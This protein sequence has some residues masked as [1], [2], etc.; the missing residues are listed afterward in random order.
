[1]RAQV[2][3]AVRAILVFTV[4][5]G[6]AYPLAIT[7]I[8]QLAFDD[9]ADGSLIRNAAGEVVGS[10]LLGQT[11]TSDEYF[12]GRPSA[13]G[14]GASGSEIDVLDE[15][16]NPTGETVLASADDLSTAASGASNLGPTNEELLA[17]IQERID[18][19]RDE[20]GLTADRLVPVDAVTASGS[21]VDPLIS[22]SNA[23]LQA[24]RVADARNMDV[25]EVL[26]LV[27]DHTSSRTLGF[28]GEKGVN[29]LE[30]NLALDEIS[31]S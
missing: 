19:Y 26:T 16:G 17:T 25:D 11:F 4:L 6:L 14:G 10:E 12:H 13:A 3:A 9:K 1:M 18:S 8:S 15:E 2:V 27:D 5:L 31:P 20:N 28:L 7:G 24:D 29:V 23:R 30:L 21:G 22:V